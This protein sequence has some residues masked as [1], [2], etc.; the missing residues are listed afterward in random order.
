MR[1]PLPAIAAAITIKLSN[2]HET[3]VIFIPFFLFYFFSFHFFV[4]VVSS[5]CS[6]RTEP[7]SWPI[8]PESRALFPVL[9]SPSPVLHLSRRKLPERF[10]RDYVEPDL[11]PGFITSEKPL[12]RNH[13]PPPARARSSPRFRSSC[14]FVPSEHFLF[15]SSNSCVQNFDS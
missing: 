10:P 2:V 5:F 7:S 12:V 11:F 9:P 1:D 6:N 15:N 3:T 13:P 8:L 14:P 4:Y